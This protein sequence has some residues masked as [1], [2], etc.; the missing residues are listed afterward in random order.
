MAELKKKELPLTIE[1]FIFKVGQLKK[2]K[3]VGQQK[4]IVEQLKEAF[5]SLVVHIM[6]KYLFDHDRKSMTVV[7]VT[8]ALR[9]EKVSIADLITKLDGFK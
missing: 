4:E 7:G 5:P 6:E 2:T 9:S 1:T 8:K 3:S